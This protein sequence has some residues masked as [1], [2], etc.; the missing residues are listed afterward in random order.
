PLAC[1]VW[2]QSESA[3]AARLKLADDAFARELERAVERRLGRVLAVDRRFGFALEQ[4]VA[5]KF[6]PAP[7]VVLIGDAARVLHPLA[8]QGVNLGFE[9]VAG[10]LGVVKAVGIDGIG[11]SEQW[12][13]FVRRRRTRAQIMVAAMDAFRTG[14]AIREPGLAWLRNVAV[15]VLNNAP[16]IKTE[17]MREALGLR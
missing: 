8:G 3:A 1:V 10:V 5:E 17:L 7:R 13:A 9:D 2:S 4:R 14:Y 16:F 15:D 11:E 12:R 6:Q